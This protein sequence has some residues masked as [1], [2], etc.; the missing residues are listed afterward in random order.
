[1]SDLRFVPSWVAGYYDVLEADQYI[2]VVYKTWKRAGGWGWTGTPVGLLDEVGHYPT[3][4]AA[5]NA[6]LTRYRRALEA[7]R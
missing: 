7:E 2:G 3:R 1:M 5:A 4:K 6:V